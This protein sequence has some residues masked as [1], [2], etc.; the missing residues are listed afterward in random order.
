VRAHLTEL[1]H[2]LNARNRTQAL[3]QAQK[4]GLVA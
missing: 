2:A 3:L 1:F 4:L